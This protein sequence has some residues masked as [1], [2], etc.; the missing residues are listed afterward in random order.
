MNDAVNS[1]DDRLE[2]LARS[3][4][5]VLLRGETGA[6]KT[7]YARKIHQ[8][9]HRDE[10]KRRAPFIVFDCG[11]FVPDDPLARSELL[12]HEKGAFTGAT[13]KRVGAAEMAE[14]GTLFIDEIGDAPPSLQK[15]LLRLIDEKKL[16]RV[17]GQED[18]TVNI[19]IIAATNR[20]LRTEIAQGRFRE[21]LYYRISQYVVDVPALR[22]LSAEELMEKTEEIARGQ[23]A[24]LFGGADVEFENPQKIKELFARHAW[25]GNY[26]ELQNVLSHA[27][28]AALVRKGSKRGA[29]LTVTLPCI[30][31]AL[32]ST[33]A[34]SDAGTPSLETIVHQ[35]MVRLAAA[36]EPKLLQL[37]NEFVNELKGAI[38]QYVLEDSR[39]KDLF[40]AR[41]K[42]VTQKKI[43]E[44]LS[45]TT[46]TLENWRKKLEDLA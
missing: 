14:N 33:V 40:G 18:V 24:E 8:R 32:R 13:D 6:G 20:D 29:S 2:T 42:G 5:T 27:L 21:D 43:A 19:R 4:V 34:E 38:G 12:G 10:K 1:M 15:I 46:T 37:V 39:A 22:A 36:P 16:R 28:V 17:G 11:Y 9:A 31:E 45:T 7:V 3:C 23:A 26:R 30:R 35:L 25:P 41:A 44:S